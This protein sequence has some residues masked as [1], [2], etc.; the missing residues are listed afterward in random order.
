MKVNDCFL[1]RGEK[2][3]DPMTVYCI[4]DICEGKMWMKELLVSDKMIHGSPTPRTSTE[5]IPE[6]AIPL[7]SD[8]WRWGKKQM[9][10]FLD[11]IYGYLKE[12]VRERKSKFSVGEHYMGRSGICTVKEIGAEKVKHQLFRLDED[13]I[14][15]IWTG[16][17]PLNDIEDRYAVSEEVYN[18]VMH[19]YNKLLMRLRG[20]F[21]ECNNVL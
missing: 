21:C 9:L 15:P 11:E 7:P 16:E 18:E 14:S 13:D 19:K 17:V 6:E 10:S 2:I 8:S 3:T 20:R 12:N 5:T 1:M 4:T